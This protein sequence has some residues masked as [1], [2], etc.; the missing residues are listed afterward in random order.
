MFAYQSANA[1][2]L[3]CPTVKVSD[4][5]VVSGAAAKARTSASFFH[6]ADL[7]CLPRSKVRNRFSR[8]TTG[9]AQLT[10][11]ALT[12][13]GFGIRRSLNGKGSK[14]EDFFSGRASAPALPLLTRP[15]GSPGKFSFTPSL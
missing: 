8:W 13:N 1:V 15:P 4:L 5:A 6:I 12:A 11:R 14:G 10:C 3:A 9:R 7:L 2:V